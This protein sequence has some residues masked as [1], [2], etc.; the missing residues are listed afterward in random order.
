MIWPIS[1]FDFRL[2]ALF[3]IDSLIRAQNFTAGSVCSKQFAPGGTHV[4]KTIFEFDVSDDFTQL[5]KLQSSSATFL[6]VE[7]FSR[8]ADKALKLLVANCLRLVSRII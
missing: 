3:T 4:T 8:Y 2:F 7:T 6:P 5:I 1:S